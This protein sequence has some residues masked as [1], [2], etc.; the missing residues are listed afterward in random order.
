MFL[1]HGSKAL[2]SLGEIETGIDLLT[3][4]WDFRLVLV[5]LEPIG[6]TNIGWKMYMIN[7]GWDIII[8][9]LI[10]SLLSVL[11]FFWVSPG[12]CERITSRRCE[13]LKHLLT[14]L[15]M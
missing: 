1:V 5:F 6:I 13:F 9:F 10:V 11:F 14:V 3:S 2:A 4:F 12:V 7:A 15:V 8:L